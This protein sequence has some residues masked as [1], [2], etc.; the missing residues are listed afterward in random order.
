MMNRKYDKRKERPVAK[1]CPF[2]ANKT[3]PDYK[4]IGVLPKYVTERGKLLGRARTGICAKHQRGVTIA[5]K[6][7]R[8]LAMLPFVVRA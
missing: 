7:A 4:E 6:R 1:N 8:H 3:E 5:V 2:C